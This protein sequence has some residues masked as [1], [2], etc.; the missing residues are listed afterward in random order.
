MR[1]D[2]LVLCS[3]MLL[4]IIGVTSANPPPIPKPTP[5]EMS[6]VQTLEFS[7]HRETSGKSPWSTILYGGPF[8]M[9]TYEPADTRGLG[10]GAYFGMEIRRRFLQEPRGPFL[11]FYI[12]VGGQL[13]EDDS[14]ELAFI[15]AFSF[16]PKI[17]WRIPL[18]RGRT[19]IDIEPYTCVGF[20]GSGSGAW[21]GVYLGLKL[22]F[23]I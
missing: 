14:D 13:F 1:S 4:L 16:G 5:I 2:A 12:G 20:Q 9:Y 3:M 7:L 6:L 17:G 19:D 15:A 21:L 11:G 23:L 8:L 18:V 10:G 22:D